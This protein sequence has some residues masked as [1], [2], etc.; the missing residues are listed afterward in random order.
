MNE[1]EF[2][3]ETE[4]VAN[5]F[6]W[7]RHTLPRSV[8]I[9]STVITVLLGMSM[10]NAMNGATYRYARSQLRKMFYP[11]ERK[12][13]ALQ[14]ALFMPLFELCVIWGAEVGVSA[15]D[16]SAAIVV[17]WLAVNCLCLLIMTCSCCS[18]GSYRMLIHAV[19]C[20]RMPLALIFMCDRVFNSVVG[21]ESIF[22]A[23]MF[24]CS[25]FEFFHVQDYFSVYPN[26]RLDPLGFIDGKKNREDHDNDDDDEVSLNAGPVTPTDVE[27]NAD[28]LAAARSRIMNQFQNPPPPAKD[29]GAVTFS[30][31]DDDDDD[32][33]DED[34]GGDI[35]ESATEMDAAV[36]P[37]VRATLNS[38]KQQKLVAKLLEDAMRVDEATD[39]QKIKKKVLA[40]KSK[41]NALTQDD[42]ASNSQ[43]SRGSEF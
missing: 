13:A 42:R 37:V 28:R 20:F 11:T 27:R 19:Q 25:L 16:S 1:T 8:M 35:E 14:Y 38:Q 21:A 2:F 15:D 9:S 34:D 10:L 31:S 3:S 30:A 36:S 17:A 29:G 39:A 22:I 43:V 18:L 24:L 12:I 5:D 32:E 33:E 23:L 6:H 4:S 26:A 41:V 7:C 40:F